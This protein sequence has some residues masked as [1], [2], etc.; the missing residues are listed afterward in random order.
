MKAIIYK[1]L[2]HYLKINWGVD[3]T[4]ESFSKQTIAAGIKLLLSDA[5]RSINS[6]RESRSA[7]VIV[8][9]R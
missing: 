5:E 1:Q 7:N 8:I 4:T 9:S 2:L 3:C 6:R